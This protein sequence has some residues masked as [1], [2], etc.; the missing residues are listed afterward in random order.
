MYLGTGMGN[1]WLISLRN[2]QT[3]QIAEAHAVLLTFIPRI[4][5]ISR[6]TS[7]HVP[8]QPTDDVLIIKDY[9]WLVLSY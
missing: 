3:T 9:I 7:S 5:L 6:V 2:E 4:L 8:L 1:C